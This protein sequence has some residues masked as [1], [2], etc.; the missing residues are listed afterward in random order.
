MHIQVMQKSFF[1]LQSH[2]MQVH[3][4]CT[5]WDFS[6]R[7]ASRESIY[8]AQENESRALS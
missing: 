2:V 3:K 1:D 7:L 8:P 6:I 4:F 5:K